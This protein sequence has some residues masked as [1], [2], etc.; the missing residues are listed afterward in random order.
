L[1]RHRR[2]R[3]RRRWVLCGIISLFGDHDCDAILSSGRDKCY[4]A[5]T[6][7]FHN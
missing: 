5:A 7:A 3:R 1:L 2:R 4:P 6:N